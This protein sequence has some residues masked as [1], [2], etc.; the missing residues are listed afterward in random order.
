VLVLMLAAIPG[1]AAA[2]K[3]TIHGFVDGYYAWNGNHPVSHESWI[4]GTGT[5][6]KRANEFNL[7]LAEVEIVRD[8]APLGFKL[9]LVAGNGADVVHAA[10]TE[11]FSHIYQA[12]VIYKPSDKL[13]LEGGIFPSHIGFE[14]FYSKDNWNYTRSW[15]GELSPY[16]QTGIHAGYQFTP[17]WAG[18]V[19]ILNGW[20]NI[21]D[22][23]D[24]KAVGGKIAYSNERFSTS[25]NT[26]DED[27]RH[28]GDLIA[29]YKVTPKLNIGGSLDRGHQADANWLGVGGYGR[30]AIDDRHAVA[31]RAE[32]FRD[33]DN[34][35]S[36]T[37]Q[38]LTEA[39]LT[40]EFRPVANLIMKLEGRRDRSTAN[41]FDG[42]KNQTVVVVGAVAT[43]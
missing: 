38:T 16:Y 4:P 30:Y 15:L 3:V 12:S 25:L 11:G 26:F 6:A 37:A 40:V 31:V 32:R 28:F 18:E 21:N 22:N 20:Q 13:T 2:Q 24:G 42:S 33:R 39:T 41:V 29:L 35:I 34:G 23:N 19:H 1:G 17:H 9:S 7:N 5:T 36:G 27:G 43:F 8:A 10:E 14:A